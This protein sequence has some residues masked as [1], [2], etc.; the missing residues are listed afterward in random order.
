MYI[1]N[2]GADMSIMFISKIIFAILITLPVLVIAE[3]LFEA[4]VDELAGGKSE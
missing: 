3:K 1:L 2:G 4:F